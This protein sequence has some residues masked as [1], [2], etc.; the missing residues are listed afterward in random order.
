MNE[1]YENSFKTAYF[2]YMFEINYLCQVLQNEE[3]SLSDKLEFITLATELIKK[4]SDQLFELLLKFLV[5]SSQNENIA[6]KYQKFFVG[7]MPK[8]Q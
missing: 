4:I 8:L 5:S 7:V 2:T 3:I 1:L 6:N